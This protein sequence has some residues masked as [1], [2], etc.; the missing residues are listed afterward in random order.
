[1][2]D[3]TAEQVVTAETIRHRHPVC[4]YAGETLTGVVTATYLRGERVW[5]GTHLAATDLGSF[6]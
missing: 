5:D 4:P 6:V 3:D 2:F 1:V